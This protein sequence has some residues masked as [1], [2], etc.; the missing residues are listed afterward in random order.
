MNDIM[1]FVNEDFGSVRTVSINGEPWLVGKDIA[2][3]LGYS[4]PHKAIRDHVDDEDKGVNESVT[5]GGRQR[6]IVI[7]ESGFYCLVL[8]SK[9]PSAKK[10]KRWVTSEVLPTIRKTG[11]YVNDA[12]KF[13]NTYLPFADEPTKELFKIQFE[14]IGQLNDRIR[15]DEPKVRFADHVSET[16][17]LIDMNEMAKI[18]ADHGIRIGRTR[19]FRWLRSKG[20]LMD[21]NLPYQEYIERG[22][23]RVKESVFNMGGELKIYR[24]TYLTGKGQQYVLGRLIRENETE[25]LDA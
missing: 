9:L 6:T 3:M 17:D 11:G 8:S 21:G 10:I 16:A 15:R 4:N 19:L 1:T 20:I 25:V 24:Q 14:Y 12:D 5:P 23:F 22:Y 2:L 7:N 18:C 13:V